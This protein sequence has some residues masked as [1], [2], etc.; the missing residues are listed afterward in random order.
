M[1]TEFETADPAD[2]LEPA[3]LKLQSC[4]CR[5]LPVVRGGRLV[6]VLTTDNV[7]EFLM[8]QAAMGSAT[9]L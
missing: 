8:V 4:S 6:G 7:G 5:S 2:M 9:D 1:R 3:F